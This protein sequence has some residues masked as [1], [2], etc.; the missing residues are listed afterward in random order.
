MPSVALITRLLTAA[1]T[2]DPAAG[3]DEAEANAPAL[4]SQPEPNHEA[5]MVAAQKAVNAFIGDS[6]NSLGLSEVSCCVHAYLAA[7]RAQ[8]KTEA[9]AWLVTAGSG[10]KSL[11]Y[12]LASAELI[13][14][15]WQRLAQLNDVVITPLY[16]HSA[17]AEVDKL[18]EA[19]D[20][21]MPLLTQAGNVA[22]NMKQTTSTVE[23]AREF[24]RINAWVDE[25]KA[26]L[27]KARGAA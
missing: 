24:E 27:R 21:V 2:P 17:P 15:S 9:V 25:A 19:L 7:L 11:Q 26:M 12:T 10:M 13:A 8:P 23:S 1:L 5:A 3:A 18:R 6:A 14:G 20:S 22:Y 16:A 4:P